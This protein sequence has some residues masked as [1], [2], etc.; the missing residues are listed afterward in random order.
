MILKSGKED[1]LF[2]KKKIKLL[3][4]EYLFDEIRN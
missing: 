2:V 4:E 3:V 1:C